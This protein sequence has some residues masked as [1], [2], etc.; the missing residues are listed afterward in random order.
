MSKTGRKLGGGLLLAAFL[1]LPLACRGKLVDTI[2]TAEAGLTPNQLKQV[3][4]V[5]IADQSSPVGV[6]PDQL[7]RIKVLK[8]L[9]P[10]ATLTV[11]PARIW[12]KE[13]D[14]AC[15][16]ELAEM[17][18]RAGLCKAAPAKQSPLLKAPL[19]DPNEMNM[20][21]GMAREFSEY[22]KQNPPDADYALYAD[23]LFTPDHWERGMVHFVLCD[24][25]GEW[26]LVDMQNSDHPDYQSVKP[27]SKEGCEKL[28]L[29][30]LESWLR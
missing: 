24:R 28:L 29:K 7:R 26:V 27:A 2:Q 6:P 13:V 9:G 11:F 8:Y 16:A 17:I 3:Y 14:A 22:V 1:V 12:G 20:L 30:R 15:A 5:E 19:N 18:S 10:K 21:L 4:L 23:F 25:R